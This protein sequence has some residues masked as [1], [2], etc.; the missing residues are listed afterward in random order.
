MFRT[1]ALPWVHKEKQLRTWCVAPMPRRLAGA[2]RPW[3]VAGGF[4]R[5]LEAGRFSPTGIIAMR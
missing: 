5:L 3:F 4:N 2:V 1:H